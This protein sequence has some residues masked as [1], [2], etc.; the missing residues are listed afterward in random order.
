MNKTK[1]AIQWRMKLWPVFI[2]PKIRKIGQ[3]LSGQMG[4]SFFDFF[5]NFVFFSNF[6]KRNV[7]SDFH[8]RKFAVILTVANIQHV[9]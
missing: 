4:Q 8:K 9:L 1:Y 6:E 3:S 5:E 2:M 7:K